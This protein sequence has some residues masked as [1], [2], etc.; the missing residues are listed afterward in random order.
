MNKIFKVIIVT[1]IVLVCCFT[2]YYVLIVIPR[3]EQYKAE[4]LKELKKI[5]SKDEG[6]FA[7]P[8]N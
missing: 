1:G 3:N 6:P 2:G 4:V 5:N 7:N 8:F